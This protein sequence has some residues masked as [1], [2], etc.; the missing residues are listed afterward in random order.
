MKRRIASDT[1]GDDAHLEICRDD[2]N[3]FDDSPSAIV[4]T[5]RGQTTVG[6]ED[7]PGFARGKIDLEIDVILKLD[8]ARKLRDA[9][10]EL[11]DRTPG[12]DETA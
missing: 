8:T 7:G 3:V 10:T 6:A 4:V 12:G 9:L 1:L 2:E 11:I 5:A